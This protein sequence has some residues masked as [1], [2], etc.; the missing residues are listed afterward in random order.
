MSIE[1]MK[2]ALDLKLVTPR[3]LDTGR[4]ATSPFETV[5]IDFRHLLG[6]RPSKA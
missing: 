2:R 4:E 5:V 3:N 6:A 1:D